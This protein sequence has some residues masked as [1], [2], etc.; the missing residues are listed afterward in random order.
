MMNLVQVQSI[1]LFPV[2]QMEGKNF[3]WLSKEDKLCA[4][5]RSYNCTTEGG[6]Q[7][8]FLFFLGLAA[9]L[10]AFRSL[11]EAMRL[12]WYYFVPPYNGYVHLK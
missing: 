8:F 4:L 10:H 9:F 5:D 12:L 7:I 1:H 3:D 11:I 2:N 6:K